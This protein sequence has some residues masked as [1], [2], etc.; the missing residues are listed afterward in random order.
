MSKILI[1][2]GTGAMGSY[3]VPKLAEDGHEIDV[4]SLE[5]KES[6]FINV[7][8]IKGNAKDISGMEEILKKKYDGIVD[9]ML[10]HSWEFRRFIN[11]YLQS[12]DH[13]IFLSTYRVYADEE[14]PI[15]E[16]S[17]R[18]L[19]VSIDK[20]LWMTDDYCIYK[21]NAEN[22]LRSSA[23]HN[24]T[25]IRPAITYSHKRCQLLIH[26][27]SD[28]LPYFGTGKVLPLYSEA[29]GVQATMTWAG[30][31]AEMQRRLLFNEKALC[32]DFNVTTSEHHTWREVADIY[33]ELFGLEYEETDE[34]TY[35][36][37]RADIKKYLCS[38]GKID[39]NNCPAAV[40][41]LRYDRMFN[42]IMDNTKVL[43]VTG[44]N[45]SEITSLYD[46]LKRER[47]SILEV[48]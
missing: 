8:Y 21:A 3:L 46:G 32:D 26:E 2:G 27:R 29:L 33:A 35:I 19:D 7:K 47:N 36:L 22:Y 11:M 28:L 31:V 9:F 40:Y 37:G 39:I 4:I 48:E 1:I 23:Y 10:Y 25:I 6:T 43:N 42:R 38:F 45:K 17:P 12:T 30:D 15:I 24:W 13:Y 5:K 34:V 41:Q 44:M 18:L 20:G 14:H 16:S